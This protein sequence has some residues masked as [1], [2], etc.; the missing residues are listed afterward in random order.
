ML[1]VATGVRPGEPWLDVT[2]V[3]RLRERLDAALRRARASGASTLV[4]VTG[5][6]PRAND[7][8][9]VVSASREA[10]EPWFSLE[11]PARDRWALATLGCVRAI[12]ATGA[13]RFGQLAK[14]WRAL[15]AA[16]FADPVEG[17][18][19]SGL[20]AVGGFAF[21]DD[22]GSSASWS[23]FAPGSLIVPALSLAR[24]GDG[25]W[26]TVN[27]AVAPDDTLEDLLARTERTLGRLRERPL[28]LFDPS[29]A[30]SYEVSS[31]MPP[32]HYEEAVARAVERIRAGELEKVVLA[33]E[34][35][36]RAPIDASA[37][38]PSS[39]CSARRSRRAMCSRSAGATRRSSRPA[40]SS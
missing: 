34:V 8:T 4:S 37:R 31:V 13:G 30:G 38:A 40:P 35:V 28:P 22:G 14:S 26:L 5:P 27:A 29:P 16:A 23:G 36:A 2:A 11:Q 20:V 6:S 21:A 12:E 24:R 19:G 7:P 15:S 18:S 17:P 1:E 10:G 33:R 3:S 32:A 39:A 25:C 9:A